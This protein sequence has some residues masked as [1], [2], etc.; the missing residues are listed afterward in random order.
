[1][2]DRP[3]HALSQVIVQPQLRYAGSVKTG[4]SSAP[5]LL[6]RLQ[7]IEADTTPF[8]GD[9]PSSARSELHWVR[10]E[11]V[12][13]VD[14]AEWTAGGRLRQSSF[15]GLRTDKDPLAVRREG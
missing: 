9:Q 4:F 10:P 1:M 7:A 12:A 11:L 6:K 13:N 2:L 15:K 8:A 14:F 3:S 5:G